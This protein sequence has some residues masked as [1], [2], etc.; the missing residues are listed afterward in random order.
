MPRVKRDS[1][2]ESPVTPGYPNHI[3][4]DMQ[5]AA[6]ILSTAAYP[7]NQ[8]FMY[9]PDQGFVEVGYMDVSALHPGNPGKK[10]N[11]DEKKNRRLERNREA[12]RK[13]P[14]PLSNN[15]LSG[16]N[17]LKKKAYVGQLEQDTNV[18]ENSVQMLRVEVRALEDDFIH[19][20]KMLGEQGYNLAL[21]PHYEVIRDEMGC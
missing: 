10:L 8:S 16:R 5:Q 17:R 14:L 19:L 20:S 7:T 4:P 6:T 11:E 1:K 9:M 21:I 2:K 18:L 15:Y 3:S 12:A 13:Y